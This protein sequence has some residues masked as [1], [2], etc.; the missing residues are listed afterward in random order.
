M[1]I[2][3]NI[4]DKRFLVSLTH[5][6]SMSPWYPNNIA[7]RNTWPY[8]DNGSHK[9]LG[10]IFYQRKNL[11]IIEYSKNI[12]LAYELVDCFYPIKRRA[13]KQLVLQLIAGNLQFCGM[14]GTT[15]TD[16]IG[17]EKDVWSY[18][19]MLGDD[20]EPGQGG[21]FINESTTQTVPYQFGRVIE[22]DAYE[23]H[24]GMAFTV[25]NKCRYS[26]KFVGIDNLISNDGWVK[27][28][29]I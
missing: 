10:E 27:F 26:I 14:D 3:D 28:W 6:L 8:G 9:I 25:P 18:I 29:D 1:K 17:I 11:D 20:V 24:K 4:F 5:K 22:I 7:N 13:Q 21:D 2:H 12:D 23:R 16:G 19:L 15:H